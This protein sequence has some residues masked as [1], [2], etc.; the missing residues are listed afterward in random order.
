MPISEVTDEIKRVRFYG[1]RKDRELL[2]VMGKE[3]VKDVTLVRHAYVKTSQQ[4]KGIGT[5]LLE[6]IEHQ[7]NTEWVL[8]GTW[9]AATWAIDFYQKHGYRIMENKNDLLRQYWDISDR[10]IETSVVLGKRLEKA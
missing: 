10:Q 7:V 8:V 4:G 5:Q 3:A 1:Y 6:F 2:G 9:S